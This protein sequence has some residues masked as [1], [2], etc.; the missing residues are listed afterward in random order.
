[1]LIRQAPTIP[2]SEITSRDAYMNRR[3]FLAGVAALGS[4]LAEVARATGPFG[5]VAKSSLS[6]TEAKT[7]FKDVAGYNNY[8]EF[9]TNKEE[10]SAYARTL[11][12]SPWTVSVEGAVA[13][14]RKY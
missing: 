14:P 6:T 11:K 7:P 3:K 2:A 13:K 1:M 5:E 8:Y 9:G 12:T 10:P 4:G